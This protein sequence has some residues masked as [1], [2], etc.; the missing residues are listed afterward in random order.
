MRKSLGLFIIFIVIV[1]GAWFLSDSLYLLPFDVQKF[2]VPFTQLSGV[3]AIALMAFG[4]LLSIRPV[5]LEPYL[6]GLDKMYRL[7]KWLGISAMIVAV[8]HWLT[9]QGANG[10]RGPPTAGTTAAAAVDTSA[11]AAQSLFGNLEGPAV[12]VA[13][14]ALW[15]LLVLVAIALIKW[16][17]Y[18]IFALTHRLVPLIFLVLVFHAVIL[19]KPAYWTQ[20]IGIL[21]AAIFL[22]GVVSALMALFR[23]IGARRKVGATVTHTSYIADVRSLLV[24]LEMAEGW[25]GHKPGQFA[26]ISSRKRWSKHPFTITSNWNPANRKISFIVKELGDATRDLY[27]KL[28][29]GTALV[30]EGPYGYFNFEDDKPRQIWV[31]GGIGI[32]PFVARMR[33]LSLSPVAK[34]ID[35]FHSDAVRSEEALAKMTNDAASS[36][37]NL[38]LYITPENGRVTGAEIRKAVPNWKSASVW[39]CGPTAF[40]A[41]LKLDLMRHGMKSKDFHHELFALR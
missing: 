37:V 14:P 29:I 24:E 41:A 22:V 36:N 8:V 20:P 6:N 30:V 32:T 34:S 23:L 13:Q 38:H 12:G 15:I 27:Q 10:K 7:H 40:A 25:K 5:W 33:H 1:G 16:I 11:Q 35:L 21:M 28:Q 26:F 9:A 39:F 18:H 2:G 17:P 4:T 31:S 3:M 19:M